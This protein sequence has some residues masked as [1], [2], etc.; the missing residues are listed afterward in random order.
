MTLQ[1]AKS[2]DFAYLIT[3]MKTRKK[4]KQALFI[5]LCIACLAINIAAV[6]TV[7][8]NTFSGVVIENTS[9]GVLVRITDSFCDSLQDGAVR[10]IRTHN[11]LRYEPGTCVKFIST[12]RFYGE[13]I[14][15]I[16]EKIV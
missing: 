7:R 13:D 11:G 5:F 1:A 15:V 16:Y 12:G 6:E 10:F 3:D 8:N 4:R 2:S 9:T 14:K